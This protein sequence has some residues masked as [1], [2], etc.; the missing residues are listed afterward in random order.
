MTELEQLSELFHKHDYKKNLLNAEMKILN[1]LAG[2]L[3]SWPKKPIKLRLLLNPINFSG[4]I[5]TKLVDP[6]NVETIED[7]K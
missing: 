7:T 3:H 5:K 2:N 4:L 6:F 1:C